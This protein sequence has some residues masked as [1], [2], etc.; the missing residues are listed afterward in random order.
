MKTYCGV[1]VQ[2]QAFLNSALN[3]GQWSA[4]R[5]RHFTSGVRA[6]CTHWIWSWVGPRI[7]LD[8]VTKKLHLCPRRELNPC[9]P[10]PNLVSILTELL[11][12]LPKYMKIKIYKDAILLCYSPEIMEIVAKSVFWE[13]RVSNTFLAPHFRGVQ[14][15]SPQFRFV[16]RTTWPLGHFKRHRRER[17]GAEI[18]QWYRAG[19]RAM[20]S[21]VWVP[22]RAGNFSLHHRVQTGSGAQP[23]SYPMGTRGSFSGGRN[24]RGVK[25]TT[26]LH[27]VP[28]S[29]MRGAIPPLPQSAFMV[30]CLVK[31]QG[32]RGGGER[33]VWSLTL[34]EGV[35]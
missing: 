18:A 16:F 15:L 33:L 34:K 9:R 29:R 8:A 20:W 10:A 4:S 24:G 7:D 25:L 6:S 14:R 27:L 12:L 28:R 17:G 2:L 26:H 11:W 32:R 13:S 19:L 1:E 35:D 3:G 30:W 22:A 31:A 21:G 5:P 23:A